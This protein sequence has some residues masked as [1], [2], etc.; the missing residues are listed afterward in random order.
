MGFA[1]R[2]VRYLTPGRFENHPEAPSLSAAVHRIDRDRLL[3]VRDRIDRKIMEQIH[4][5][6]VAALISPEERQL[7]I[8][9]SFDPYGEAG[10]RGQLFA[11]CSFSRA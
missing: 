4:Q 11:Y 5:T 3:G 1:A 7:P 10:R 8:T 9:P 6:L 2:S